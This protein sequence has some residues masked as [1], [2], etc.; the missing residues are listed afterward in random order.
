MEVI[1]YL[2][3]EDENVH[4]F[5]MRCNAVPDTNPKSDKYQWFLLDSTRM[6]RL[7]F[8]TMKKENGW[9]YNIFEDCKLNFNESY[10]EF[11]DDQIHKSII[12]GVYDVEK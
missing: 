2:A 1:K 5:E 11:Y 6:K 8:V 12:L 4:V 3:N 10:G 9:Q 7:K